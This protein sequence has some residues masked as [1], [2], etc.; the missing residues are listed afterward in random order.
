MQEACALKGGHLQHLRSDFIRGVGFGYR[1]ISGDSKG[2]RHW[3]RSSA[4]LA[5]GVRGLV[6]L[7]PA[8]TWCCSLPA[9]LSLSTEEGSETSV[10]NNT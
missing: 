1:P 3:R 4:W 6:D 10:F 7:R 8:T 5:Q 9:R 2:S